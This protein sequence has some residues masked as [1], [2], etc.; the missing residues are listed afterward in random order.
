VCAPRTGAPPHGPRLATRRPRRSRRPPRISLL[1]T[2]RARSLILLAVLGAVVGAAGLYAR[3]YT[4]LLWYAEIGDQDVYWTTL[5]WKVLAYGMVGVGTAGFMLVHLTFVEKVM[6]SRFEERA[7]VPKALRRIA[8]PI[9]AV[10]AGALTAAWLGR[11]TSLQIALWTGRNDF[12]VTDPVFH[13]DVGFFVFTLPLYQQAADWL[14][15]TLAI[16]GAATVAA[17]AAAGGLRRE[18]SFVVV[19]GV[20]THLL[21]LGALA[22]VV[23]SWRYRLDQFA[24]ALPR[25]GAAL[26]GAGYTEAHVRLP[27]LKVLT[28][29]S[30]GGA[31]VLL[32]AAVGRVPPLSMALAVGL[33]LVATM[34]PALVSRPLERYVV[35]PQ[36]LTRE[37]PYLTAAIT[38]TRRAFALDRVASR[39]PTGSAGLSAADI[40][41][42]RETV[43]NV[44]LWDSNVLRPALNDL[45]SL[46]QYYGFPSTTLDRYTVDGAARTLTVAARQ[47]DLQALGA[48]GR[49]W[50]NPRFAYTH[51]FGAV[52]VRSTQ[53]DRT[54]LPDLAQSGFDSGPNP[55]GLREPRVY[56]GEQPGATPPYV[57]V[58]SGRGE[59]DEP[60]SGSQQP[61]YHYDGP[62]G[63][64]LSG[65]LRRA[66]FSARFGDLNLLLSETVTER[67]RI[68][69]HR[70]VGDRLRTLAPFLRWEERPQTVIVNGRVAF[71]FTGYT[72]SDHYPYSMPVRMGQSR[73]NY[74]RAAAHAVVDAFSGEVSIYTADSVDPILR[75]WRTVYPDLL[76]PASEMPPELRAHLRYPTA[77][78]DAQ[79]KAYATYHAEATAFWNGSDAWERPRQLAGPV[80]RAGDIRFPA[81]TGGSR[82]RPGYV[83]A[84]LPGERQARAM[85][86]MPFTPRGRQN[87][88]AYLAGSVGDDGRPHLALLSLPR[89]KLTLGPSQVTRQ[90]LATPEVSRRLELA[91]RESRDLGKTSVDRTIVGV[92]RLVPVGDTLVQVQPVYL[93]AAGSGVP[94]LRL[95]AVQANGRV[96]YGGDVE[97]ALRR[98]LPRSSRRR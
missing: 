87:L 14:L 71:L 57:V 28:G 86:A 89:N 70:N 75:A 94:R 3:V 37:R 34:A 44:P 22:L 40:A 54:G 53:T 58:N 5:K 65:F 96:G 56:F 6:A 95:V 39:S 93:V 80:E 17:Y 26:P 1:R 33:A 19:R 20:R 4:D 29:V 91:N 42:N 69:L 9:A 47:L 64:A 30:L 23:L 68:L 77:L 38:A 41:A 18:R 32:R 36:K 82:M 62:G 74:V 88:V 84:R 11:E 79:I 15:A 31:G 35:E 85:L 25:A 27:A 67:S 43:A 76:R 78:F 52:A 72:T 92:P 61:D 48:D 49:G 60:A 46:G 7:R 12:G 90:I 98:T 8:Y 21:V 63:I 24:L 83:F 13:R 16:T 10:A 2:P 50:T 51:G 73:V 45:Q 59:V 81:R 66:A 97:T 55:L